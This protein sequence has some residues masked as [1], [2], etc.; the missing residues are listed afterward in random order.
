MSEA[1]PLRVADRQGLRG[2]D[3]GIR[4]LAR[5]LKDKFPL[6][7]WRGGVEETW[8]C[9]F[10]FELVCG[11][12]AQRRITS[13]RTSLETLTLYHIHSNSL[14]QSSRANQILPLR[15][16]HRI[17][18]FVN[19]DA[20]F[21]KQIIKRRNC[22]QGDLTRRPLYTQSESGSFCRLHPCSEPRVL[23]F[24][25]SHPFSCADWHRVHGS[26]PGIFWMDTEV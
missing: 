2:V 5:P 23:C 20:H 16:C 19:A 12:A 14:V 3:I 18:L 24:A 1:I 21:M 22:R 7:P 25:M 15:S 11:E 8:S 26:C 9:E 17:L 10:P 13:H 6:G 4:G